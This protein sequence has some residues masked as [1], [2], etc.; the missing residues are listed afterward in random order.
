[1]NTAPATPDA[2]VKVNGGCP[3]ISG[4]SCGGG[5]GGDH[6]TVTRAVQTT[7]DSYNNAAVIRMYDPTTNQTT[8]GQNGGYSSSNTIA[9][10]ATLGGVDYGVSV[11]APSGGFQYG[12]NALPNGTLN[13]SAGGVVTANVLGKDGDHYTITGVINSAGGYTITFDNTTTGVTDVEDINPP[14]G[15]AAPR[16]APA[17]RLHPDLHGLGGGPCGITADATEYFG[18]VAGLAAGVAFGSALVGAEPVAA[19]AGGVA[20]ISEAIAGFSSLW[21]W[22]GCPQ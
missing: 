7:Y 9:T 18:G 5:G 13:V 4:S 6:I 3:L 19:V 15:A 8:S 1:M 16:V 22:V 20:A 14:S 17:A 10:T 12:N 2:L 21:H 11:T